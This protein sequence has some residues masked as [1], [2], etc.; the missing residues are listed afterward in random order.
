[1]FPSPDWV[2]S[3]PESLAKVLAKDL[4]TWS[5][6]ITM[7]SGSWLEKSIHD[8]G[9]VTLQLVTYGNKD[10]LLEAEKVVVE[11]LENIQVKEIVTG[12]NQ[13]GGGRGQLHSY[14]FYRPAEVD[15]G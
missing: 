1:M 4:D 6:Q 15:G 2:I 14:I 5:A 3:S 8:S 9:L 10:G 7:L 11:A 12:A 13:R